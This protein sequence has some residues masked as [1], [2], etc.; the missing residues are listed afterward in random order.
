MTIC[1]EHL[2]EHTTVVV[3]SD[4]VT[5]GAA[6]APGVALTRPRSAALD[7][8]TIELVPAPVGG[9]E[10]FHAIAVF[11]A[12]GAYFAHM[13]WLAIAFAGA[14]IAHGIYRLARPP[15]ILVLATANERVEIVVA[16]GSLGEARELVRLRA[17]R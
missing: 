3:E 11:F 12:V 15:N 4:R 6:V 16:H 17:A 9:L 2:G 5:W 1:G 8:L 7:E 10:P 14:A 13:A